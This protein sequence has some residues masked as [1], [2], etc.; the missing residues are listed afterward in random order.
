MKEQSRRTDSM[1][2]SPITMPLDFHELAHQ[3]KNQLVILASL[4]TAAEFYRLEG[5][6]TVLTTTYAEY[7]S[8]GLAKVILYYIRRL[9]AHDY[10]CLTP[11]KQCDYLSMHKY[12]LWLIENENYPPG[13]EGY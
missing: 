5:W 2:Q 10:I 3:G 11:K 6:L 9:M 1:K 8:C 13:G 7:P 12:W 4:D